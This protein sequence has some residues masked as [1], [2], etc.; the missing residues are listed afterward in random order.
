MNLEKNYFILLGQP[1]HFSVDN[2]VLKKRFRVLQRQYH[3]DRYAGA[4]PQEQR[5]AVQFS[6][7]LNT[8][9]AVLNNPVLRAAHLLELAGIT[10]D[11][12][13][14]TIKDT[15]FLLEQ[16][17]I[18]EA[19]SD[20]R[21][22]SNLPELKQLAARVDDSYTRC[23]QEFAQLIEAVSSLDSGSN[24]NA[25]ALRDTVGKM[26]FYEKLSNELSSIINTL[27]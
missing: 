25:M 24:L 2:V 11:H 18:R 1:Q 14:S 6:A 4:T 16:M 23:Q 3:P 17:D 20:A 8:A 5:L 21:A 26:Q 15:G 12:Q 22:E 10:V 27:N 9:F 19:I 7:H 13:N